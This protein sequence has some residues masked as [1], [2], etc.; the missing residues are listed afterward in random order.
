LAVLVAFLLA[1]AILALVLRSVI[2]RPL[3]RLSAAVRL[4]AGGDFGH[5][6]EP[7]SPA[8]LGA[9]AADIEAMRSKLVGALDEARAAQDVAVRQATALDIRAAE[10]LRS[11]AE[12]EQFA[13]V[14]SHDLQERCARWPRSASS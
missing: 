1:S 8:D 14:A 6:I 4:V 11:N 7:T 2:V 10:L 9:V 3:N 13:Y 5:R 12:L